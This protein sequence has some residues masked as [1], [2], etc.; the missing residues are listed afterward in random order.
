[1][2]KQNSKVSVVK[3]VN[4]KK[5][6]KTIKQNEYFFKVILGVIIITI[7][8]VFSI[9][10]LS[11]RQGQTIP[12]LGVG[13]ETQLTRVHTVQKGENLWKISEKYF[14]TGYN[15]VDIA[16]ENKISNP[17]LIEEGKEL[18]IPDVQP[19]IPQK[20]PATPTET[21]TPTTLQSESI[22]RKT[23]HRVE[24]GQNLWK[25][26]EEYFGSGYNWIDVARVNSIKNSN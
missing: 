13:D 23:V 26:S 3:L 20:T 7:V 22:A 11:K 8:G 14:G 24:K 17:D 25:I 12:G 5:I 19:K 10:Y 15:W 16:Q 4:I 6:L 2:V 21:V 1:M 18:K 9:D